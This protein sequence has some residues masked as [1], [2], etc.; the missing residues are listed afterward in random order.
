VSDATELYEA[1][2]A[3]WAELQAR[4]LRDAAEIGINVPLDWHNL[5][6]EVEGLARS[7][8]RALRS[9]IE[10][11]LEHLLRRFLSSA[12]DP[13]AGWKSTVRHERSEIEDLLDDNRSLR[14][15][16]G[17]LTSALSARVVDRVARD[18]DDPGEVSPGIKAKLAGASFSEQ[19]VLGDWF[20]PDPE[21]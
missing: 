16:V 17:S 5:A 1:D 14:G 8:R 9:R 15:E 20:P 12:I 21:I 7:D 18:L 6:E 13:R 11:I 2:Y 4:I 10:T 3:S 19:Q